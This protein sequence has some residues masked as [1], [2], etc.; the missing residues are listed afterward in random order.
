MTS[1]QGAHIP[2]D[3]RVASS[4]SDLIRCANA[5]RDSDHYYPTGDCIIRV[6]DTLFKIHKIH[7]IHHSPVFAS[8]FALPQVGEAEGLSDDLPVVLQGDTASEFRAC[9]KYI[10]ASVLDTQIDTI[11]M[12]ALNDIIAVAAFGNKYELETWKTWALLFISRRVDDKTLSGPHLGALYRLHHS[13]DDSSRRNTL[14][15]IW[16]ARI[17]KE[18]L[19]ISDA[20]NIAED[21]GDRTFLTRLYCLQWRRMTRHASVFAPTVFPTDNIA[22]IHVQR[23]YAGYCSL[24][25]AWNRLREEPIPF[26][27][28]VG[29]CYSEQAHTTQ[30]IPRYKSRWADG[31]RAAERDTPDLINMSD[32]L[33]TLYSYLSNHRELEDGGKCFNLFS[34]VMVQLEFNALGG[35][36]S[37]FFPS[38]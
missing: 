34:V 30:C 24:A 26:P 21:C 33:W 23:I 13:L 4:P 9:L 25:L 36:Q 37:H 14:S 8:M 5:A 19:V 20:M 16:Y 1:A 3:P 2:S 11:P 7:L 22:P 6:E 35:I 31:I 29:W 18:E 10:Y 28:Q 27:C 17:E 32:R 38:F 15:T 12:T